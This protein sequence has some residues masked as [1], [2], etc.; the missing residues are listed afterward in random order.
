MWCCSYILL[1]QFRQSGT[2]P[3]YPAHRVLDLISPTITILLDHT[4][5]AQDTVLSSLRKESIAVRMQ[6]L[7]RDSFDGFLG[8]PP[9]RTA[10]ARLVAFGLDQSFGRM[11]RAM[12]VTRLSNPLRCR[13]VV[14]PGVECRAAMLLRE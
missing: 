12:L 1:R 5:M 2:Q 11:K 9:D 8:S 6:R 3:F 4:S 10:Q 14:R 7:P 13:T